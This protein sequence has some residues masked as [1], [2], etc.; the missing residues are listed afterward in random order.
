MWKFMIRSLKLL[1]FICI[2]LSFQNSRLRRSRVML[3][4]LRIFQI[5]KARILMSYISAGALSWN[6]SRRPLKDPIR[7]ENFKCD[8]FD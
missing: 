6:K 1:Q 3:P 8:F 7:N 5:M 4:V 2:K